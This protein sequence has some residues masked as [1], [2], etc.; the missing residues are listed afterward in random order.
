ML[1][2]LLA[3]A[4]IPSVMKL[5][6][7]AE[8]VQLDGVFGADVLAPAD[9][10]GGFYAT[11]KIGYP[12]STAPVFKVHIDTG[13]IGLV[14]PTAANSRGFITTCAFHHCSFKNVDKKSKKRQTQKLHLL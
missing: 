4:Y 8:T 6:A 10:L 5:S 13:S 14:I 12:A 9:D 11:I 3:V 1:K 2:R 7:R